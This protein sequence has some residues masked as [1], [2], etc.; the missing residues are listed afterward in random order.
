[1]I[2]FTTF[3]H[4]TIVH[5]TRKRLKKGIKVQLGLTKERHQLLLEANKFTADYDQVKF[6]FAYINCRSKI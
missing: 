3:R 1:M 5:M 6:C 4:K 2:K